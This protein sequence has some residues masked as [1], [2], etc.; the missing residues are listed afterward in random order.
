MYLKRQMRHCATWGATGVNIGMSAKTSHLLRL[1]QG[2]VIDGS[3]LAC[4]S[5]VK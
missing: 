2:S 5:P 1:Q 3:L 4:L